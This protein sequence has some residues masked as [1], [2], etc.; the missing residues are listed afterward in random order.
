MLRSGEWRTLCIDEM[1]L[2]CWDGN[3]GGPGGK[4]ILCGGA[5]GAVGGQ[6]KRQTLPLEGIL[7]AVGADRGYRNNSC[8]II[9]GRA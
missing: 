3:R 6:H 4:M 9:I 5:T 2:V 1:G 8:L 7:T